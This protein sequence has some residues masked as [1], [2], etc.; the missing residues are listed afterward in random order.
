MKGGSFLRWYGNQDQVI[1][2]YADGRELKARVEEHTGESWSKRVTSTDVYFR[3]GITWSK[4]ASGPFSVRL[5]P[6]G[7]LFDVGGCCAFPDTIGV[8]ELLGVLNSQC[9]AGLLKFISPTVNTEVGQIASL[10]LPPDIPSSIGPLVRAAEVLAR[11]L[12]AESET[13]YDFSAPPGWADGIEL[14]GRRRRELRTLCQQSS[15]NAVF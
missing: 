6:G 11:A 8:H 4:V 14:V 1:N 10:P 15:E 9:I 5:N 2:F 7:F 13:T 12:C 3:E